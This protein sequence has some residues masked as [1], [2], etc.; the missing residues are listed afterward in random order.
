MKR[1]IACLFVL[2]LAV[3]GLPAQKP[4][5][6]PVQSGP[7]VGAAEMREVQLWVQLRGPGSVEF[8][9]HELDVEDPVVMKTAPVQALQANAYAVHAIADQVQPGKRYEASLLVDGKPVKLNTPIRFQSRTLWQYRSS[10]PDFKAAVGSCAFINEPQYDRLGKPY[11]GDPSI[12]K[13]IAAAQ[14][15]LMLWLGDNVYLREADWN[16]RTGILHRYTHGRSLPELQPLLAQTHHYAIWDDHDFGPN[17]SDHS[18]IHKDKTLEAFKLFWANPTYGLDGQPGIT[19][20]FSWSDCDFFLLD[21]RYHRTGPGLRDDKGTM[22][23]QAQLDWLIDALKASPA[24]FKFIA[25]GGMVLSTCD[26]YEDYIHL[27]PEE[28]QALLDAIQREKIQGVVFLTGDRH[29]TELSK[30]HPEGGIPVYDWTVSP[31]TS[32][33]YPGDGDKNRLLVK[34]S[35]YTQANFGTIEVTGELKSRKLTLRVMDVAGK[36]QW[37]Q[38]ILQTEFKKP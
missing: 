13:S 31:L 12:F 2:C 34:G 20:M 26:D 10:P 38:E 28:R 8:A 25:I 21:N 37:T 15:D 6:S 16:T 17:D 29:H 7:M 30:Y 24:S 35:E 4:L 33:S 14:P 32:G 23:G 1:L 36:V 19:S 27:Y 3:S 18:F 11:G 5:P 9:Y 22:L